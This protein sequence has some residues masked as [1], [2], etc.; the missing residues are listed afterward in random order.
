MPAKAVFSQDPVGRYNQQQPHRT[1]LSLMA[2]A[3]VALIFGKR[4]VI[5]KLRAL[6]PRW[7][8]HLVQGIKLLSNQ[9]DTGEISSIAVTLPSRLSLS[10]CSA[11][12]E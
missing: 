10:L 1:K 8:C 7:S 2:L 12:E 4:L 5:Q 6:F 3:S 11:L 9:W